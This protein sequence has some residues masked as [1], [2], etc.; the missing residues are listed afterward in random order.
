MSGD[1]PELT[2]AQEEAVRRQLA[3]ARHDEP[4]PEAVVGRLDRVLAGLVDERLPTPVGDPVVDLAS[5]RRRR[6]ATQLLVAAVAIVAV[7]FGFGELTGSM[8]GS[9]SGSGSTAEA[10]L[11]RGDDS[12]GGDA[13][14]DAEASD[15]ADELFYDAAGL[16]TEALR[17]EVTELRDA[18][19]TASA[20]NRSLLKVTKASACV[21]PT[22]GEKAVAVEVDGDLATLLYR[23]PVADRQRVD[24]Y[25][26]NPTD[27]LRSVTIPG[28]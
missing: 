27:R 17:E 8:G 25:R 13:E 15:P 1:N 23:V 7:G 16:S 18:T 3:A 26:C 14:P 28:P 2:P 21:T 20:Q 12:A 11:E 5:R 22:E 6:H 24:L 4:I 19:T 9:D 10:G